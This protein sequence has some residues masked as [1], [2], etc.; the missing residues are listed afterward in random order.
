LIQKAT[1]TVVRA[2]VYTRKSTDEG[3]DSDFNSLDCQRQAAESYIASQKAEGWVCLPEHYDDGGFSGA[4][5]QRP[6]LQRL[7]ADMD[8]GAFD[9]LVVYRT[10]RLSRSILDFLRL[11]ERVEKAGVAYVSVTESFSTGTPAGRLM[12]HLLLSFAQYERE[13]ISERTRDKVHAARRRGRFT[14]STPPMGYDLPPEGRWLVVNEVEAERVREIFDLYLRRGSL[15][16]TT[17]ELNRR[18]WTTKAWTSKKGRTCGGTQFCK[19]SLHSLLTNATVAGL[20]RFGGELYPGE[21][22]AVVDPDLWK[23]VQERLKS[24]GNGDG[25]ATKRSRCP[26]LLA[27]ILWCAPCGKPM[28]HTYTAKGSRRYRY[29]RCGNS[30]KTG[31]AT[32]PSGSLPAAEIERYVVGELAAIGRDEAVVAETVAQARQLADAEIHRLEAERA[33]LEKALRALGENIREV[34]TAAPTGP[35][36]LRMADLQ[37]QIATAQARMAEIGKE[38]DEATAG[39]IGEHDLRA[40]LLDFDSLWNTMTPSERARTLHALVERVAYDGPAGTVAI[41][42]RPTGIRTLAGETAP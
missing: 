32:C 8:A 22:K 14:G 25:W 1:P 34:G 20:V 37:E 9:V 40:A 38:L 17:A 24:N 33:A 3:L 31:A 18:G 36:A 13:V 2:A 39:F 21:H 41:T 11:L 42:F 7:L 12:M 30:D 26:A 5:T 23:R 19:T 28:G 16:P 27:G 4:T 35:Q 10:D 6:A 15:I 29:Y